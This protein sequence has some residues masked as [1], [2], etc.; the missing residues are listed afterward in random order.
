[1]P[2]LPVPTGIVTSQMMQTQNKVMKEHCPNCKTKRIS[3]N[4]IYCHQC[5]TKL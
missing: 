3:E 1:M 2:L 5:G 4:A